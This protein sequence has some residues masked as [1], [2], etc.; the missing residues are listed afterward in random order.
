MVR[1]DSPPPRPPGSTR[2]K[3]DKLGRYDVIRRLGAGGMAEVYLARSRGAEGV[4]KLVVVKRILPAHDQSARMRQ[5]FVDEARLSMRLNHPNIVQV[6]DFQE[7]AEGFLLCMEYVEGL[8]L[9]RLM[10]SAKQRGMRLPPWV[11]A[12]IVME[13]AR[14][15][16]CAHERKGEDGSPLDI[17]HRDVSPQNILLS[18]DGGVKVADFGIATAKILSEES[19]ILKGKFAYMSPEQARGEFVDRRTD[20][21][22]LGI[23]LHEILTGRALY[24]GVAGEELLDVV[25]KGDVEAPSLWASEVPP[26]LDAICMRALARE[27]DLRFATA[28]DMAGAIARALQ[29]QE[30]LVDA[31][32]VEATI[33]SFVARE[34]TSPGIDAAPPPP[35]VGLPSA[36]E[37]LA[38]AEPPLV[39][40]HGDG[41]GPDSAGPI[42]GTGE[43]AIEIEALD[44]DAAIGPQTAIAVPG[45]AR[46]DRRTNPPDARRPAPKVQREVRH[47]ALIHIRLHGLDELAMDLGA[48]ALATAMDG[49]RKVLDGIAFK[50]GA[51]WTWDEQARIAR[52]VVGLTANPSGAPFEAAALALDVHDALADLSTDLPV[53]L[54]ASVGIVRAIAS[55]ERDE[56]AHLL[57]HSIQGAGPSLA[58]ALCDAA[59]AG[60][61]WVAG[62]LYRLVRREFQW[63]DAPTVELEGPDPGAESRPTPQPDAVGGPRTLR[64][65]SLVRALTREERH[66]ELAI[67]AGELVGRDV[68]RADLQAAYHRAVAS[69][70]VVSRLIV[71]EMGIG[72]TALIASFL[73]ELPPDARALRL[74]C[75]P[76]HAEV[77][78]AAIGELVR[79]ACALDGSEDLAQAIGAIGGVLGTLAEGPA[80]HVSI[81]RLAEVATG[82]QADGSGEEDGGFRRKVLVSGVRRML[83]ALALRGPLV[84]V[85][86]GV[87]W[88]DRPSL[89]LMSDLLRGSYPI[90]VLVLLVA[91]SDERIAPL[92]SGIVRVE[93]RGL[94]PD[95][96]LRLLEMRL[97][98][99]GEG[100][101]VVCREL[102]ARVGGNPFFLL[103]IVDALLERGALEI[104]EG[105]AGTELVRTERA[106]EMPLPTTLE[107]LL[108]ERL[109]E[110][111]A[112]EKEVAQWIAVMGGP[113][114]ASVLRDL[115]NASV[116]ESAIEEAIVRL[117][118]RGI[119]DRKGETIDLRH[120]VARDVAYMTIE[121]AAKA[122]MHR[123]LG[124]R[125]RSTPLARGLSAAIVARH[126]ARG[127][128][129]VSAA[130]MFLEAANAARGSY[131]GALA[132]RYYHR[133]LSL[134]AK[135]DPRR[136][137][138]HEALESLYRMIG[139]RR[140]RRKQLEEMRALAKV[141]RTPRAIAV[142]LLRTARLDL[143]EEH[144][145]RGLPVA[146]KAVHVAEATRS[147][148]LVVE[149]YALVIEFLRELGDVEGALRAANDALRISEGPGVPP[150]L[151]ADVLR[152]K[153]ILLRRLGRTHEAVGV[154][155]E[156]VALLR[157]VGAKRSEARTKNALAYA[158]FVLARYEDAIALAMS[159][160][161]LDLS[162]GGRFQIAKTLTNIGQCYARLGDMP[163]ALAYLKRAR[164]AHERY[165]D[166]DGRTDTLL[167]SAEILVWSGDL[168]GAATFLG[169][170]R[171]L[172]AVTGNAYDAT[173]EMITR[174]MW[175]RARGEAK[176][177]ADL[178]AQARPVA[179]SRGLASYHLFAT[180]IEAEA[181][182]EADEHAQ[183]SLLAQAA[184]GLVEA[185]EGS[186]YALEVR[187]LCARALERAG[188]QLAP[189]AYARAKI[190]AKRVLSNVREPRLRTLFLRR[191]EVERL[192]GRDA[193]TAGGTESGK[194]ES[195][196]TESGETGSGRTERGLGDAEEVAS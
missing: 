14:G 71:G 90:P 77:P 149:A 180:A 116:G 37:P 125:L 183:A 139:R 15:L 74:E 2:A 28:R 80:A 29:K 35:S 189:E 34:I 129:P 54:A 166:Q 88:G 111:P 182:A 138:A 31:A 193:R 122:R 47:V 144:L 92:L 68:E 97:G 23:V 56:A 167:V 95:E 99:R 120:P 135:D 161:A 195:G 76:S 46:R 42:V 84:I 63:G 79:D 114:D 16:H 52:G 156:S 101:A 4:H 75:A 108:A 85:V 160:V 53:V 159:S 66:A 124:E 181:R 22:A 8:D 18:Y 82:R 94:D 38:A 147:P 169:D 41:D 7:T 78:Y 81:E 104:R 3:V 173:H 127:E 1:S 57:R 115:A 20:I 171:A 36:L 192:L 33:S 24:S 194:T 143:D 86:E 185:S 83:A 123:M 13:A 19:G 21:Y 64:A 174:A 26:E 91:R 70:E 103:E 151:R 152:A 45:G 146:Q 59:P 141:V 5:M 190:Y 17:V 128:S 132:S 100:V 164:D 179:Q 137:Q 49:A 175:L 10:A 136:F 73:R 32:A 61:T 158:M 157:S 25:R 105:A 163:R 11:G 196:K 50:H 121:P 89:E 106:G 110:L 40:V 9:G 186:E 67:A 191:P 60:R 126:L 140:E 188:D 170:A 153:G 148:G 172:L 165:G 109:H 51:R 133:A 130:E 117:C 30:D 58:D 65:Y 119:C 62:G 55:G 102:A 162:I 93:L 134:M 48:G 155:A 113:V 177:A 44:G 87:Q 145:A 98:A 118:A 69:P 27:R 178:A 6:F 43:G 184:I 12:F 96:Q 168:D 150:R 187:T 107:Q 142:A 131:Q 112:D 154:Y 39:D 176:A 72:K